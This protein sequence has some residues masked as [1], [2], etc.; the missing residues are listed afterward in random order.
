MAMASVHQSFDE[1]YELWIGDLDFYFD[2]T[3]DGTWIE[4]I[5]C[6]EIRLNQEIS[7]YSSF[8]RIVEVK[9]N[10]LNDQKH[11]FVRVT[12]NVHF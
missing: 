1:R 4:Y 12:S 5:R 7:K 11:V 9:E 10:L 3:P 8:A 6:L 2:G